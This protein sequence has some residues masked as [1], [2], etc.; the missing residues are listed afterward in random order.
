[1]E[2]EPL[3]DECVEWAQR[4]SSH[5]DDYLTAPF[6]ADRVRPEPT[7]RWDPAL[8]LY[9]DLTPAEIVDSIER[10]DHRLRRNVTL[11]FP[12]SPEL[13]G[14]LATHWD[15]ATRLALIGNPKTMASVI[16]ILAQDPQPCVR[17]AA[18]ARLRRGSAS[19]EPLFGEILD[20]GEIVWLLASH[21][22]VSF[23]FGVTTWGDGSNAYHDWFT[24]RLR[25]NKDRR[26]LLG[27][28]YSWVFSQ[29]IFME[30]SERGPHGSHLVY[31]GLAQYACGQ[32][33]CFYLESGLLEG[34]GY[35]SKL[36][37]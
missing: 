30:D 8:K 6:P 4:I 16:A 15:F 14:K 11:T 26:H 28:L 24:A 33:P 19:L 9:F 27:D 5:L 10:G 22:G 35:I 31:Y 13:Q 23:E 1:M 29:G 7:R 34:D 25:E 37:L 18:E 36:E 12:I 17:L 20:P 3:A 2:T 21:P 32:L